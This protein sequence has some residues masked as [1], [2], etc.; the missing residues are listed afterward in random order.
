VFGLEII[1][2]LA[3]LGLLSRINVSAFLGSVPHEGETLCAPAA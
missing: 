3:G 1:A 2:A